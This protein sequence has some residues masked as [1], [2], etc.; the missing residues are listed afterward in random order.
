MSHKKDR[1]NTRGKSFRWNCHSPNRQ[2]YGSIFSLSFYSLF[3]FLSLPLCAVKKLKF[4]FL[5]FASYFV[6]FSIFGHSSMTIEMKIL[7]Q[8]NEHKNEKKPFKWNEN[9]SKNK[10]VRHWYIF[11]VPSSSAIVRV[12]SMKELTTSKYL[13]KRRRKK[14]TQTH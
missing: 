6:V 14:H 5:L 1:N 4:F 7:K 9:W 10:I 12:C 11:W 3:H 13:L 2:C 8:D